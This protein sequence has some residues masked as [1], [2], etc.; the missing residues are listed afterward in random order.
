MS[1]EFWHMIQPF[2]R[3]KELKQHGHNR[4][5]ELCQAPW[6]SYGFTKGTGITATSSEVCRFLHIWD[7][8]CIV[9]GVILATENSPLG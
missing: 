1:V 4:C 3:C 8:R 9:M 5:L 2:W 7:H 6:R